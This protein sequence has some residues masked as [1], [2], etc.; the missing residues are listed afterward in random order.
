MHHHARK[1]IPW[2]AFA[3]PLMAVLVAAVFCAWLATLV[4]AR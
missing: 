2:R 4:T 3:T 1:G